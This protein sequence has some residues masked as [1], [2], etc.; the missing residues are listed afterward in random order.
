MRSN[1]SRT[2]RFALAASLT[3]VL[4]PMALAQNTPTQHEGQQQGQPSENQGINLDSL[5]APVRLGVRSELLRRQRPVVPVLVL[6]A[7][8]ASY[9]E[10]IA[11]W[12]PRETYP[13]LFDDGQ[14]ATRENIARFV[15]SFKPEKI[16]RWKAGAPDPAAPVQRTARADAAM[17]R[18][19]GVPPT[20]TQTELIG[21]WRQMGLLP[22]GIV[23]AD[24]NDPAWTAALALA[25]GRAELV[26][27]VDVRNAINDAMR[28][29]EA[30]DYAAKIESALTRSGLAWQGLGD[31]IDAITICQ[32]APPKVQATPGAPTPGDPRRASAKPGDV[33]ALTDWIGRHDPEGKGDRYAWASQIFGSEAQASYRAMSALFTM[34]DRAWLFDGYEDKEPWN[35]WDAT[36]AGRV[37]ESA[38]FTVTIDDTPRQSRD[39]WRRRASRQLD[40]G[41][42]LINSSGNC[43]FFNLQPGVGK[44]GDIPMLLEPGFVHIVHSWSAQY[45][46]GR[47][48][49]CGRWFANGA[50]AYFGSVEEPYLGA[51]LPT[52]AIAERLLA[53]A[54]WSAACRI[55]NYPTWRLACF[56]DALFTLGPPAPRLTPDKLPL[57]NTSDV[58]EETRAALASQ[59]IAL[60]LRG[61]TLQGR[62]DDA[63]RLALAALAKPESV[64]ASVAMES[65]LP[66]FR[67][68]NID[69]LR[70]AY[71]MLDANTAKDPL[72]RDALWLGAIPE[73][74]AKTSRE[75]LLLLMDNLRPGQEAQDAKDIFV[76]WSRVFGRPDAIVRLEAAAGNIKDQ[77]QASE[78]REFVKMQH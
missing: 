71:E 14:L 67:A 54:P 33:F 61:L 25:A 7:D 39:D 19:W 50:A 9:I 53:N 66:L 37:L 44:P 10:A 62:D 34:P 35:R 27:W 24:E 77:R 74:S 16:V 45:P 52:P 4:C 65:I 64:N 40:A 38:K 68:G 6:V 12:T 1:S 59:N 5:P 56:G 72:L 32:N 22:P 36:A 18:S 3:S 48:T 51:F 17:R 26:E 55:D 78:I 70:R 8:E 23:I 60:G 31:V 75:L 30:R 57:E 21:A 28:P 58:A 15:R 76:P 29:D 49:V 43:D 11:H 69:A 13:V 2:F 41:I 20:I 63:A 73:L 46:A 42:V 47:E